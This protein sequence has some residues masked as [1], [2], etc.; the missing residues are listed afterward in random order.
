MAA[1]PAGYAPDR[2]SLAPFASIAVLYAVSLGGVAIAGRN[3]LLV[4]FLASVAFAIVNPILCAFGGRWWRDT[5]VSAMA[6][7]GTFVLYGALGDA[8]VIAIR[9]DAMA[10]LGP[11]MV[12][13]A[14]VPASGLMRLLVRQ[15]THG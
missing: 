12:Y 3:W 1:S 10:L 8:G 7:V 14:A 9:E 11:L 6:F 5:A 4:G 2:S 15:L 13:L